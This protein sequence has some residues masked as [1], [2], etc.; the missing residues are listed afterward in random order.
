[1]ALVVS[2][3]ETEIK[4]AFDGV[5]DTQ[6]TPEEARRKMAVDLARAIDAYIKSGTVTGSCATPAGPGTIAGNI[7]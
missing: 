7:I 2:T 4:A 5:S 1:M 6:I 3:L